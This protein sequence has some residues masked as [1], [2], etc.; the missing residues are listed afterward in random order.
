MQVSVIGWIGWF[1]LARSF[2]SSHAHR[3]S[4]SHSERLPRG[5]NGRSRQSGLGYT[6][7]MHV[8][9]WWLILSWWPIASSANS[10]GRGRWRDW[11]WWRE[12]LDGTRRFPAARA[13]IG[14]KEEDDTSV[15]LVES[16]LSAAIRRR[17]ASSERSSLNVTGE[18]LGD[19]NLLNEKTVCIYAPNRRVNTVENSGA[20][21]WS[22]RYLVI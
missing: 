4:F 6:I 15:P 11:K 9:R 1:W 22:R 8:R 17:T 3:I 21:K 10:R 7:P 20:P 16:A 14:R 13:L 12:A 19:F 2:S 18:K 5:A